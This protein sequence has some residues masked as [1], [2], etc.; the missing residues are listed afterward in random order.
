MFW[1]G[2]SSS[3]F[4]NTSPRVN[5]FVSFPTQQVAKEFTPEFMFTKYEE[6]PHCQNKTYISIKGMGARVSHPVFTKQ[7]AS[8]V[9]EYSMLVTLSVRWLWEG[10]GW[11]KMHQTP[12]NGQTSA[13]KQSNGHSACTQR[14]LAYCLRSSYYS[15]YY[16]VGPNL[17]QSV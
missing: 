10:W 4:V 1:H 2:G 9:S 7:N 16:N 3:Y 5:S 12:N 14:F 13:Y 15:W 8:G 6:D 11:N 17:V